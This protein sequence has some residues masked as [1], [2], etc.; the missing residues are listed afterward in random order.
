MKQE[1]FL[2]KSLEDTRTF[3]QNFLKSI[4]PSK[5]G[6]RVVCLRGNLGSGKTAL[7]KEIGDVLGLNKDLM[8]SPT[9]V[10]IKSYQLKTKNLKLLFTNLVHID[11]YRLEE[12]QEL[13]VLG[14]DNLLKEEGTIIFLEWPERVEE[15]IPAD[16]TYIEC[17]FVDE[18][19]REYRIK[20]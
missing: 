12:A 4:E 16:A 19:T 11:A 7:V 17:K 14:W 8:T 3:A 6:A 10:L 15:I 18:G 5:G 2:S 1:A 20:K 13:V 9:F